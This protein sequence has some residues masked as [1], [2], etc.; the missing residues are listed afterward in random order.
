LPWHIPGGAWALALGS[1]AAWLLAAAGEPG[2]VSAERLHAAVE[3]VGIYWPVPVVG[4][5]IAGLTHPFLRQYLV[6]VVLPMGLFNVLGSLQN[7]E[8]AEAARPAV[9]RTSGWR[10]RWR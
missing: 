10:S 2:P 6:P 4:D 8:S 7:I 9:R 1:A 5:L 3:T